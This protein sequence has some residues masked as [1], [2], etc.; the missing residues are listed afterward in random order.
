MSGR[1]TPHELGEQA[2]IG[3]P[4]PLPRLLFC[5]VPD[6]WC[7]RKWWVTSE[8]EYNLALKSREVHQELCAT[9]KRGVVHGWAE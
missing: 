2:F 9:V 7:G 1:A 4:R 8:A 5:H 3:T 6:R